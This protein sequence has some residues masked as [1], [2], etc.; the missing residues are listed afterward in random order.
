M[1]LRLSDRN[2]WY[3]VVETIN[4]QFYYTHYV[5][6]ICEKCMLIIRDLTRHTSAMHMNIYR[7]V[8]LGKLMHKVTLVEGR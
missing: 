8:V 7:D 4:S 5:R 1:L 3:I 6:N 2:L